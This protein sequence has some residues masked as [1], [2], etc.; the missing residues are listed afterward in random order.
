[1]LNRRLWFRDG[2]GM[3]EQLNEIDP[4]SDQPARV[5]SYFY[6]DIYDASKTNSKQRLAQ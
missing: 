2:R 5:P 6:I 1:M 4:I 3:G